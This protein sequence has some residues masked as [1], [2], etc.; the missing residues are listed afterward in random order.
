LYRWLK[1]SNKLA[2]Q[3]GNSALSEGQ[4]VK[5]G[6]QS[7]AGVANV[8]NQGKLAYDRDCGSCHNDNVG[9]NSNERMFRLD[10]VGRF[11]APTIY[12]KD[13]QSIRVA[14]L[15]DMY[16][17]QSR[18]LLSDGHVRNLEDLVSPDRCTEGSALYNQ[19]YTLHAP[20]RPALGSPD[21]PAAWPDLNRKGDVFRVYRNTEYSATDPSTQRNRFIER[22]KYFTKVSWD[23]E[24]YY[25]DFQKMRRE[26]GPGELG[27][28]APIGLPATPHPWCAANNGDVAALVQYVLTK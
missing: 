13:Q 19:Y 10:E 2:A 6:W 25:W 4:F 21:Q 22:H 11:F 3:T 8:V 16:W 14:Y 1:A 17:V 20:V 18:G 9:A 23:N 12:Q 15:R 24:N 5:S 7:Y 26:Y 28:A 27:T